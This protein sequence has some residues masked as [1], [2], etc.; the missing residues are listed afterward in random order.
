MAAFVSAGTRENSTGVLIRRNL[1]KNKEGRNV[2][3]GRYAP[4]GHVLVD[5]PPE[6]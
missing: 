1:L 2:K 6:I 5:L 4:V 3:Y